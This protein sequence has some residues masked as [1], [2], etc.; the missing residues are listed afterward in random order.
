MPLRY[1]LFQ[2]ARKEYVVTR[3]QNIGADVCCQ[4]WVSRF[5]HAGVLVEQVSWVVAPFAHR[6]VEHT[7]VD[8]FEHGTFNQVIVDFHCIKRE[9]KAV[10][11]ARATQSRHVGPCEHTSMHRIKALKR[12]KHDICVVHCIDHI[13]RI[14]KPVGEVMP[15]LRDIPC[16][17][18]RNAWIKR[19]LRA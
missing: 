18:T 17:P 16:V 19:R 1:Q 2:F 6:I 7:Q 10:A 15:P 4:L 8:C 12:I 3:P 9:V 13:R 5:D 14:A 11:Q